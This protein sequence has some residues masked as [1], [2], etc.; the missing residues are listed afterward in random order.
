M[1]TSFYRWWI[2]L[3]FALVLVAMVARPCSADL[4]DLMKPKGRKILF[5]GDSN[6]YTGLYIAYVEGYLRTRFPAEPWE[7]INLGLPSET[8]SGLSEPDHPY[9]RP[10]V[11]E[12]V[13]RA[14]ARIKPDVVFICYGMNDGIYYPFAEKRLA[15]YK[16][17]T[18]SLVAKIE[19]AGAKVVLMTPAPFDSVPVKKNLLAAGAP[20][21]SWMKPYEGYDDVLRKYSDYLLTW[22]TK[23][24]TVV[25]AHAAV[26]RFLKA[27]RMKEPKYTISGDG[28]HPN[29]TGHAVIAFEILRKLKVPAEADRVEFK[30][31]A[32]KASR[33]KGGAF[34]VMKNSTRVRFT[35]NWLM[36]GDPR[37]H[38][39]LDKIEH[40]QER[41][42]QWPL[43]IRGLPAGK[44]EIVAGK[45]AKNVGTATAAEF[46]KGV[47]IGRFHDLAIFAGNEKLGADI[48][49]RQQK[50]GLAWLTEIG[51]KRPG[52]PRL[53]GFA[54]IIAADAKERAEL[55]EM[56]RHR[57]QGQWQG[58]L[59]RRID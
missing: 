20:K 30:F 43:V 46:A 1:V 14:L 49:A 4:Q 24:Y 34:E 27:L 32:G 18:E 40:V 56:L 22:R 2:R 45:P 33:G 29:P 28:I 10:D 55:M 38:P 12:R 17:G 54:K 9:P 25:D 15:K 41:F 47:S 16:Q 59:I 5:L 57:G 37:W 26:H 3:G 31:A 53:G 35:G 11:H 36:P 13:D 21:Y 44:Y 48:R 19:K 7:L 50:T 23:G 52:T 8:V 51:H 58:F 6:T 39:Q 42:N